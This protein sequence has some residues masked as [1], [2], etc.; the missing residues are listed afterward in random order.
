[1]PTAQ[2]PEF[3]RPVLLINSALAAPQ[4][5]VSTSGTASRARL[6]LSGRVSVSTRLGPAVRACHRAPA[7]QAAATDNS[8]TN[9]AAEATYETA[10]GWCQTRTARKASDTETME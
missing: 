5:H 8:T 2:S 7:C 1:M 3:E 9:P 6:P 4:P 10:A